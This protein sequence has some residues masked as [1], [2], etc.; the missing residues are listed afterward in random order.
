MISRTIITKLF[1]AISTGLGLLLVTGCEPLATSFDDVED[2]IMYSAG[3]IK[4]APQPD[5]SIMVMTWNIRFGIGRSPW[6][7]DACSDN[8]IF[9]ADEVMPHLEA[10]V[11][12][13]DSLHPDILFLQECDIES[14]RTA[15]INELQYIL[16]NT[17][18]NYAAYVSEWKSEYIPSDGLGRMDMGLVI[19]SPWPI[20]DAK[21]INLATRGDQAGI[22]NYFYLHSCI[23]TG[24]IHIPGFKEFSLLNIHA[25][26]FATDDTKQKHF[27]E[28]KAELDKIEAEGGYFLAGGDLNTLPP[29]SDSTDFCMEDKCPGESFHQPGDDPQHKPGSDYSPETEWISPIFNTYTSAISISDFKQDPTKYFTHTTR[30]GHFWDRTLD[31]LYTNYQWKEGSAKTHQYALELSDHAAVSADFI[32]KKE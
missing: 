2:A 26:A 9:G 20:K 3:D 29:G 5:S 31:Y 27:L 25:S 6:F 8:T 21:R 13:I 14:K 12:Q 17:H 22:V 32:L 19:L 28:F 24:K 18:F 4:A 30:P 16:D 7:G 11:K 23:V 1:L 10:I 15:Y